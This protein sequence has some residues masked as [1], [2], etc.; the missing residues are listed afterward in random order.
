LARLASAVLAGKEKSHD[1]IGRSAGWLV[2]R[3]NGSEIAQ[4]FARELVSKLPLPTDPKLV[5]VA[6]SLQVTGVLLCAFDRRDLTHCQCFIDLALI[7]A[8]SRVKS[9]LTA[10]LDDWTGLAAF[11]P[12]QRT[13][14]TS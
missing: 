3:L 4:V 6:R 5:A 10:A 14:T 2:S 1:L 11:P 13:P 12:T 7:E 8:G 9:I